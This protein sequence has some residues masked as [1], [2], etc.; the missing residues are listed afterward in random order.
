MHTNEIR[1]YLQRAPR[2]WSYDGRRLINNTRP[3]LLWL[4]D[5][6]RGTLDERINRRAG[7]ASPWLPWKHP[8]HSSIQRHHRRNQR[9]GRHLRLSFTTPDDTT[10]GVLE[11]EGATR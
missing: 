3:R 8:T 10:A 6:A 5:I 1:D 7:F 9:T 2:K 4:A 11:G